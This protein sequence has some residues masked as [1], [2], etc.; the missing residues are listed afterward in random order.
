MALPTA[1]T[2]LLSIVT[3]WLLSRILRS[4]RRSRCSTPLD[5]PSSNSLVFGLS[6]ELH[7]STDSALMFEGW[8]KQYGSAYRVPFAF[9]SSRVILND[10]RAITHFYA[11]ETFTYV[12]SSMDR[13]GV[14]RLVRSLKCVAELPV[15][16]IITGRLAGGYFGLKVKATSGKYTLHLNRSS[17]SQP[18]DSQRKTLSP[19]FTTAAIR[20][21]TPIFFDS[22]YKV[23]FC[24]P[25]WQASK[26]GTG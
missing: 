16:N 15:F 5:G 7:T 8:G 23:R 9:G 12:R 10:P 2:A 25:I 24:S 6:K 17:L 11:Q 3:V 4:V 18:V 22:G 19:A 26:T 20:S 13:R 14:E 21:L 1:T